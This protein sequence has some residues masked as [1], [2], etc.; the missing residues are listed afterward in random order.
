MP[1]WKVQRGTSATLTEGAAARAPEVHLEGVQL[2]TADGRSEGWIVA[3][4]QRMSDVLNERPTL[5]VCTDPVADSWATYPRDELLVVGP[6]ATVKPNPRRIHRRHHRA[7]ARVGPYTVEGIAHL[8]PGAPLDAYVLRKRQH[9][10]AMTDAVVA[11][12]GEPDSA[13]ELPVV[14]VNLHAVDE[15]RGLLTLA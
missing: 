13:Q 8:P 6:P 14:L 10:M 11:W 1:F 12:A 9:F 3:V 5:R 15:L 4:E 2:F 7:L